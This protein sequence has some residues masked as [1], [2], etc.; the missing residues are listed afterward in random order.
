MTR[1]FLVPVQTYE[2]VRF[3]LECLNGGS[4]DREVCIPQ[5]ALGKCETF[6]G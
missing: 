4:L 5:L 3:Q 6:P 2:L 1:R